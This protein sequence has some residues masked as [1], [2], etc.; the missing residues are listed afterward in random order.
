MR[1]DGNLVL[2]HRGR[3]RWASQTQGH[4]GAYLLVRHDGGV[5]VRSVRHD[6]LWSSRTGGHRRARLVLRG[7]DGR[8]L[9]VS[10]GGRRLWAAPDRERS[11][12]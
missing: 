3:R 9:V 12:R 4:P 11:M 8:L 2:A 1:S 10:R 5:V 7:R 6:V